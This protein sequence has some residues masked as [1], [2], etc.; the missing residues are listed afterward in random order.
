[1][2]LD[3]FDLNLLVALDTLLTEKHVT[4]AADKLCVSQPAMSAALSRLRTYFDDPLLVK[5]G[6]G[7]ELTPRAQELAGDV[8]DLIFRI[9]KTLRSQT[10][11]DPAQDEREMRLLMSDFS[12]SVF[13]PALMRA[14]SRDAPGVHC[15]VE[16]LTP[17]S[18]TRIDHGQAEFC[19]TVEQRELLED[20]AVAGS[21]CGEHLFDDAFVLVMDQA[22]EGADAPLTLTRMLELPY[23]EV[24][25]AHTVFSVIEHAMR[26]YS[27]PMKV[28]A[29]MPSFT[30]AAC[31]IPGTRMTTIV[32]SRLARLVAPTFGLA[33]R[34]VPVQ[35]PAVRETL[36]WH[37]R[38]DADPAHVW[39]RHYLHRIGAELGPI[40]GTA[41]GA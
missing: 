12:A 13:M 34:P 18:L 17:D 36:I 3:K 19:I 10:A 6:T 15:T 7:L 28:V 26:Q 23:V 4:R 40:P 16:H 38:N 5:V 24:R 31:M 11:F 14:L 2:H 29:A 37:K 41:P 20:N 25:F 27:L 39:M 21:L 35:L 30:E 8:R 22:A 9:R 32:P 33:I 1:M